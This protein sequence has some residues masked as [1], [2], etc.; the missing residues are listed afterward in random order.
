MFR[1]LAFHEDL[2]RWSSASLLSITLVP[3]LMTMLIRGG[4]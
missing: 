3:V 1:P 2:G 4:D